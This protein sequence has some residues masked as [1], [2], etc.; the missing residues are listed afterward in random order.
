MPLLSVRQ[1]KMKEK[2]LEQYA[3]A[4][5]PDILWFMDV[6]FHTKATITAATVSRLID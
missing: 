5:E 4:C 2:E 3:T 6:A 1:Q